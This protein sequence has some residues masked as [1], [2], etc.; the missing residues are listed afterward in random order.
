MRIRW[1]LICLIGIAIFASLGILN[2]CY[3]K[4]NHLFNYAITNRMEVDS[5]NI[6][7]KNKKILLFAARYGK[8]ISPTYK[9][10]VCTEYVIKVIE[11]FSKLSQDQKQKINIVTN[12]D[13]QTLLDQDSPITKGVYYSLVSSGIGVPIDN[14][15]E[16]KAGDFV[17]FWNNL[18][19]K[20][21]G[22]CGIVRAVNIKKGL[23]SIYSSSPKTNGHG[24]QLY[25]LPKY[26]YF[27]RLK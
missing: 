2:A 6:P 18:N 15:E 5:I 26:T 17:Q 10:A 4:V 25:I 13:L 12:Q 22:H 7:I 20:V 27:T 16:V 9:K 14:I 1:Y 11:Q 8:Q 19:G 24:I 23:L 21:Q 3:F